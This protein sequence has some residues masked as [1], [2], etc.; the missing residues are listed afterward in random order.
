MGVFRR[1]VFRVVRGKKPQDS[2]FVSDEHRFLPLR[3][4]VAI[5][6]VRAGGLRD[7][8]ENKVAGERIVSPAPGDAFLCMM[9]F[10]WIV[11]VSDAHKTPTLT[12]LKEERLTR[13]ALTD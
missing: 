4:P 5:A 13:D 2:S 3:D 9:V 7:G 1:G 6:I 12:L 10:T 11:S 8:E